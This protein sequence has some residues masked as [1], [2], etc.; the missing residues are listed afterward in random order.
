[1]AATLPRGLLL[2]PGHGVPL[3]KGFAM[4]NTEPTRG[5]MTSDDRKE[6]EVQGEAM[7]RLSPEPECPVVVAQAGCRVEVRATERESFTEYHVTGTVGRDKN[8]ADELL[9]QVAAAVAERGIQPIQEKFYGLS[10]AR[11][12]VLKKREAAYRRE[13][14]D[15]NMPVTWLQ[16]TPLQDGEFVGLQIWGIVPNDNKTGVTTVTNASTG[17]GR[18]WTGNG[19]RLLHLP[20]V[21]GLKPGGALA[22]DASAQAD[23]MFTNAELGLKAHGMDFRNVRRT[24][25]YLAR[26][27]EWYGEFNRVRTMHYK[28]TGFGKEGGTAFPASTGIQG[29]SGEEECVMD[30]LALDSKGPAYAAAVPICRSPRQ[31]ASFNY[32]SAFSRGMAFEIEGRRTVHISGTASI[33]PAG[34]S[35]HVGNAE[36]QSLETLMCIAAILEEQGG[37]LENITSATLFCKTRDAWEAWKRVTRLLK[38]PDFPKVCVLADVCRHDLLVEMEVVATI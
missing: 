6:F 24:W 19:F 3:R 27:L 7:L 15:L 12:A 23:Q 34:E 36:L 33:N 13:E 38:V 16:G 9:A 32:G 21:R 30:V 18:L 14:L 17:S 31:D 25:I 37:T 4:K 8:S 20:S 1:M 26:L 10:G 35:I 5:K 22:G 28:S 11:A 2:L 29:R